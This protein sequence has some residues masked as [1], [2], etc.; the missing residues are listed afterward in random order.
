MRCINL[1]IL[2]TFKAPSQSLQLRGR[3]QRISEHKIRQEQLRG[4]TPN[5]SPL[6]ALH[7]I[8]CTVHCM[9]VYIYCAMQSIKGNCHPLWKNGPL[10]IFHE[11]AP[12]PSYAQKL[13]TGHQCLSLQFFQEMQLLS[14]RSNCSR[15]RKC[16]RG[17]VAS[18][19]YMY[20][21]TH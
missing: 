17:H 3:V 13:Y 16:I 1:K 8:S 14:Q 4:R 9:Q 19:S 20:A 10:A 2:T 18:I 5:D 7:Y 12:K 21:T 6:M 11:K 15:S